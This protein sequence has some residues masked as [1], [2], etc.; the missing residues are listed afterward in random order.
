MRALRA[1]CSC[2]CDF[3]D[4]TDTFLDRLAGVTD[5]EQK[6]KIIGSDVHR[7]LRGRSEEARARSTSSRRAR[8]IPTSSSR[9]RSTGPS[10][11]HQE[12]SQRR[13]PAGANAVRAGRAAARAVQGRSPR[14]RRASSASPR[15]SS[16]GSRSPARA[17]PSASSAR[18]PASGSTL[19]RRADAIVADE[20]A[21]ARAV[22]RALAGL[23]GAAAGAER[24]RD[25]RRPHLRVTIA[26]RAVE[27]QR[28]HDRRLGATAARRC[29]PASRRA[30]STR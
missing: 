19:L 11:R 10:A 28:L 30:S 16:G 1:S 12:P 14:S 25:G 6:R 29:W 17:W 23:R 18:S 13:R 24:R 3:V 20:I 22:P 21:E 8:S 7:R 2:R 15:R 26:I 9:C 27:S 5:P 4:A